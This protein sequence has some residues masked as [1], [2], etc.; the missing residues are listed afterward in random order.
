MPDYTLSKNDINFGGG[1]LKINKTDSTYSDSD[2]SK[3]VSV[4]GTDKEFGGVLKIGERNVRSVFSENDTEEA[5]KEWVISQE[6]T[7]EAILVECSIENFVLAIGGDLGEIVDD[8]TNK[9]KFYRHNANSLPKRYPC[10]YEVVNDNNTSLKDIIIMPNAEVVGAVEHTYRDGKERSLKLTLRLHKVFDLAPVPDLIANGGFEI[11]GTAAAPFSSWTKTASGSSLVE[12]VTTMLHPNTSEPMIHSGARACKLTCDGSNSESS[13]NQTI[14]VTSGQSYTLSF[15]FKT[16]F[17]PG[18]I[19]LP[20]RLTIGAT[21]YD[22][23]WMTGRYEKYSVTF[24]AAAS[25]V[26]IK[27]RGNFAN[28]V[29]YVDDVECRSIASNASPGSLSG[30]KFEIRRAYP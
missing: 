24:V 9:F 21:N 17:I 20:L 13:V 10:L 4:G 8:T 11:A 29:W 14:N 7:F 27:I 26:N 30:R 16:D 2:F 22:L 25:T 3:F 23:I 6:I 15:W 12:A 5:S 18:S 1:N 28:G 19:Q